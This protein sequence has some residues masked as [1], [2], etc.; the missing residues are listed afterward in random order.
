MTRGEGAAVIVA[1][2]RADGAA[3]SAADREAMLADVRGNAGSTARLTM[4]IHCYVQGAPG[5]APNARA[6]RVRDGGLRA[7]A[8]SYRGAPFLRDH[9]EGDLSARGGT[10]VGSELVEL[11][12]GMKAIVQ[13]VELAKPWA[14]EGVLDGTIDRFSTSFELVG[15]ASCTI[16]GEGYANSWFGLGPTCDHYPGETYQNKS[17][18]Q[19]LCEVEFEN[20]VGRETSGVSVPA[21]QRTGVQSI[22]AALAA[23]DPQQLIARLAG[24]L[25]V[26]SADLARR[27]GLKEIRMSK[28]APILIALSLGADADETAV[29]A[30]IDKLKLDLEGA[31]AAATDAGARATK[32]EAQLAAQVEA[33]KAQR[34]TAL[35]ARGL[36]EGRYLP[37][38][39]VEAHVKKL[40]AKGDVDGLEAYIDD[41]PKGGAVPVG[42]QRQSAGADVT[43]PQLGEGGAIV[44]TANQKKTAKQLG[45]TEEAYAE[46]LAKRN[47][48]GR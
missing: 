28:L 38:S 42:G 32:A 2:R 8:R 23:G 3:M 41:L 34:L 19:Q 40:A 4:N 46:S 10:I 35:L 24:E 30:G 5:Q 7:L 43:P 48:G 31:R 25:G 47:A 29:L 27:L 17:G 20:A 45:V 9:R 26:E 15:A 14:I 37:G 11:A 33:G 1:L 36:D 21:V 6:V 18:A 12:D 22:S 39:K 13:D 16:C 44:L